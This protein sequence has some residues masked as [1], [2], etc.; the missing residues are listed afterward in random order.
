L[1]DSAGYRNATSIVAIGCI[2]FIFPD[3]SSSG[4]QGLKLQ[5]RCFKKVS[6]A[7]KAPFNSS[8]IGLYHCE[9]GLEDRIL[10]IPFSDLKYKCFA[11]PKKLP[12]RAPIDPKEVQQS[13]ICQMIRHSDFY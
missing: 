1:K 7:F 5:V 9:G 2:D 4:E 3:T 8:E 10:Q 11:I 12:A 6:L 13:W